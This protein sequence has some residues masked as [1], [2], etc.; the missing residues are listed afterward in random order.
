MSLTPELKSHFLNLY[1]MALS[2]SQ[3]DVKE[4]EMLYRIGEMRGIDRK[5]IETLL[6]QPN[7]IEPTLPNTVLEKIDCLY[8][9]SLIAWADGIIDKSER[10]ALELFCLRFGFKDENISQ[11]CE[12]LLTE[13]SNNTPKEQILSTVS[14][15]L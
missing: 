11:I 13:A 10:K 6:L 1:H 5:E 9:L 7:Q 12:F 14:Q 15:N 3:V 4:L 8:D 2:D